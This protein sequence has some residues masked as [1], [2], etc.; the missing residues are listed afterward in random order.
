MHIEKRNIE[1]I[2][3]DNYLLDVD[4]SESPYTNSPYHIEIQI[5]LVNDSLIL[6]G[7]EVIRRSIYVMNIPQPVLVDEDFV[8]AFGDSGYISNPI[9][10]KDDFILEVQ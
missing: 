1:L 10:T 4:L 2:G 9:V 3:E 7:N 5:K 6:Y 8:R